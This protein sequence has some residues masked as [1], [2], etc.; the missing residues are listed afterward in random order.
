MRHPTLPILLACGALS[1][2]AAPLSAQIG[3]DL[4]QKYRFK[5]QTFVAHLGKALAGAGDVDGD[6]VPD[7]ILQNGF[8]VAVKSGA[9]GDRILFL[10]DPAMGDGF[11]ASVAG[12]GDENGDGVPDVFVG[13][14]Q[15]S[16]NG[17]AMAGSAF[18][19]SGADGSL[20][21]RLDG[22]S[23]NAFFGN[24]VASAGDVDG[25][26]IPDLMVG[27]DS[28]GTGA[29]F[30]FSGATGHLVFRFDG[31]DQDDQLGYSVASTGDLDG[32]GLS[33]VVV[34]APA[35]ALGFGSAFILSGAT[36]ALIHRLD[37]N[38]AYRFGESVAGLGDVD[39]DG[40][41][42]LAVGSLG[43]PEAVSVFSGATGQLLFTFTQQGAED[44]GLSVSGTGDMDR[45]G[46]PDLVAG[47]PG[48]FFG[49]RTR[50]LG[51][52]GA[53]GKALWRFDADG[54]Q[55]QLGLAVAG[56]GDIDGD[57]FGDVIAGAPFANVTNSQDESGVAY[58]LTFNPIL[59][60]SG[61]EFS[62]GAGGTI[63][64]AIDFPDQDAGAGYRVLTSA[65]GKGPTKLHGLLVPLTKDRF[66]RSSLQG[67]VPP[68]DKNFSGIL[69][70]Q[71]RASAR[72]MAGPNA[73]PAKLIGRTFQLAVVNDRF[74]FASIAR[75]VVFLP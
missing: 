57:G 71:G 34:G 73:F 37:G 17:L 59:A 9:T 60:A 36:G 20:L 55:D 25:D 46:V 13:A 14:L 51:I 52:S 6:G 63:D 74:D 43:G 38:F 26:G 15:A 32:D 45:D 39:L 70:G 65:H 2:L 56:I 54:S 12:A 10:P 23:A 58:V 35:A 1:L 68:Q 18:L 67:N 29:V 64:Y 5:G 62:V 66:F 4:V 53:T 31:P 40:T 3:G 44:L 61:S 42:D 24:A 30:V 69:D 21:L 50:V 48:T 47:A 19:Y 16:P 28:L 49:K 8:D 11:G 22:P 75:K 7:M 33:D 41:P 72:I 27:D